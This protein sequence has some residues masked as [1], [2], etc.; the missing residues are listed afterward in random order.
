MLMPSYQPQKTVG[1]HIKSCIVAELATVQSLVGCKCK[2]KHVMT[3]LSSA[4]CCALIYYVLEIHNKARIFKNHKHNESGGME[5]LNL[6]TLYNE[7]LI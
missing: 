6:M 3:D 4:N 1:C 2:S 7:K 5:S